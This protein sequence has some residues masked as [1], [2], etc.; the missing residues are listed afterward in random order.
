MADNPFALDSQA[1]D[2]AVVELRVLM[3]LTAALG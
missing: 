3:M 1:R 2:G